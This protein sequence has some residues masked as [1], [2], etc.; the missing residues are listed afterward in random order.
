[1]NK[2]PEEYFTEQ[3]FSAQKAGGGSFSPAERAFMDKYL[4]MGEGEF[5]HKLGIDVASPPEAAQDL[6]QEMAGE[7]PLEDLLRNAEE[8]QMVGFFLGNQEF[9]IPTVAVQEVIRTMP[10]SK[11]PTAPRMVAGVINLRGKVTPLVHLRD[12][13][14]VGSPR[15]GEDKFIIVCRRQGLQLGMIIERVHTMYR[16]RQSD[17]DWGIEA[18]LGINVDFVA[19]LLKLREQLVGIVSV[20]RIIA[21]ILK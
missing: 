14:A 13:L 7:Q 18:H 12:L 9:T 6:H 10:V 2:S 21:S 1:M 20:D 19:G 17:I 11:L 4:G 5:L 16:V 3:N 8:L 15:L